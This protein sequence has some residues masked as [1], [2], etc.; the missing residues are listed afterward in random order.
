M[1]YSDAQASISES[2]NYVGDT[3]LAQSMWLVAN[4]S[5]LTVH[6]SFLPVAAGPHPDRRELGDRL[7]AGIEKE[8]LAAQLERP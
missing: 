5:D 4:A 7:R 8:L 1:R 3:T 2:A 6:V